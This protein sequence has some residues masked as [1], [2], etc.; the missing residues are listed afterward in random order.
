MRRMFPHIRAFDRLR[1]PYVA[2]MIIVTIIC[3]AL[4][5]VT[6]G[7]YSL[8][9]TAYSFAHICLLM[10]LYWHPT[11]CACAIISLSIAAEFPPDAVFM[12]QLWCLWLA[13]GLLGYHRRLRI[14][15]S[16]LLIQTFSM[17]TSL[18][19]QHQMADWN[20]PGVLSFNIVCAI[21][22][23]VGYALAEHQEAYRLRRE[24]QERERLEIEQER[25]RR[26]MA[27]ASR[28]HDSTT[29]GLT[30]ISLLSEQCVAE[31]ANAGLSDGLTERIALIGS[32]ARST[33]QDVRKVI[34]V[35]NRDEL[36]ERD[37]DAKAESVS[38]EP[39]ESML[40]RLLT[41]NDEHMAAIGIQGS[42]AM[43]SSASSGMTVSCIDQET[44]REIRDLINQMYTNIAVHGAH[45]TDVYHVRMELTDRALRIREFNAIG[46][47]DGRFHSGKGLS[48]HRTRIMAMGGMLHTRHSEDDIW[49]LQVEIPIQSHASSHSSFRL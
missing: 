46:R 14:A 36:D 5:Y 44:M 35:L 32:T 45:G 26:D 37:A 27:L 20:V 11:S 10:G 13:A 41:D 40:T 2:A 9:Q 28:I 7:D 24:A 4:T 38:D 34:D 42:S 48:M 6:D 30:L 21:M 39:M 15:F 12:K 25:L 23:V 33:L 47:T 19:E 18:P 43:T 8:L 31:R 16:L 1:R 29:R 49:T 17:M 22:A 3:T